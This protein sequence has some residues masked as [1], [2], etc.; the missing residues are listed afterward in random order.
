MGT[1]KCPHY[2][3]RPHFAGVFSY[4]CPR[5]CATA[6]ALCVCVCVFVKNK[7]QKNKVNLV[8]GPL[9]HYNVPFSILIFFFYYYYYVHVG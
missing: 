7:L 6:S 8:K 5:K 2:L 3:N 9:V 1:R 4:E